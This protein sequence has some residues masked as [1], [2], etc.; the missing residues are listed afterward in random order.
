MLNMHVVN[1]GRSGCVC[2][3]EKLFIKHHGA[4]CSYA[5]AVHGLLKVEKQT[6]RLFYGTARG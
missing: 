4:S 2:D 6:P 1:L 3:D 5:R